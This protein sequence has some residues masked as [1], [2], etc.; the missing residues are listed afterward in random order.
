MKTVFVLMFLVLQPDG[1]KIGRPITTWNTMTECQ[2]ALNI[3]AYKMAHGHAVNV[4][5]NQFLMDTALEGLVQQQ[6][7]HFVCHAV[8]TEDK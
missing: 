8:E 7:R 5:W 1:S 6:K 3:E 4:G 2:K